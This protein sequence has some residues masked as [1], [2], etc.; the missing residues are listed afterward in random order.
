MVCA[1]LSV[2]SYNTCFKDAQVFETD[3]AV[4]S[5]VET[6]FRNHACVPK[7]W[8]SYA[9][10]MYVVQKVGVMFLSESILA[11]YLGLISYPV[12]L[13]IL[14]IEIISSTYTPNK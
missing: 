5:S 14:I 13:E 12:K 8:S 7:I 2:R 6:K 3:L 11:S 10:C 9:H 4:D 1:S